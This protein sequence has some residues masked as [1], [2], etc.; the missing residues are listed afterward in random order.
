[1]IIRA[2]LLSLPSALVI[3]AAVGQTPSWPIVNGRQLQPTQQQID[4]K[5]DERT[6]QRNRDGQSD[7]D[8]LYE[9][10]TRAAAPPGPSPSSKQLEAG[11]NR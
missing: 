7:I 8:R 2:C 11:E 10:I 4:S 3:G 5:E 1:V 6:R 9:E